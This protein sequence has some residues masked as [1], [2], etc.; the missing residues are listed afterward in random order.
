MAY[1]ITNGVMG[2]QVASGTTDSQGNFSMTMG[3]YTGPVMLQMSG[4]SYID[5]ATGATM[6]MSPGDVMTACHSLGDSGT[7][8]NGNSNDP[9]Y[10]HGPDHG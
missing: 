7:Y 3:A 5:E 4:G 9:A 1:G 2:T 10:L 8:H 6:T